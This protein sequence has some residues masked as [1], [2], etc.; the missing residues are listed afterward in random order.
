MCGNFTDRLHKR[1]VDDRV[2]RSVERKATAIGM[3]KYSC[4]DIGQGSVDRMHVG[5]V[6]S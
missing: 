1:L 2:Y 4:V 3:E 6:G 5:T